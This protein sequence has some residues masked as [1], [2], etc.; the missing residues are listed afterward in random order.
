MEV[1]KMKAA[2]YCDKE[3]IRVEEVPIPDITDREMLLKI[4]LACICGT[5][6]RIFR[7]GH[8]KIPEGAKRVLGHELVG[9][10]VK[11][12]AEVRGFKTGQRV[13][14]A[15]NVGCGVCDMCIRGY[16]HMCPEYEAFG[17]S[18]DGGF[19]EYMKIPYEA[20]I[21]GN[22][23]R[24][25]EGMSYEEAVLAEP[26]SCCFN[27]FQMLQTKPTDYVLIIGAGPIGAMHAILHQR[28]GAA[29]VIMADLSASRLEQMR[30]FGDFTLI[31]TSKEELE[32][33]LKRE[34]EGHGAD[35][36]ITA[37]SVPA[38]QAQALEL[39]APLGR[40]SFFGGLPSG[41]D[42]VGLHTNLIH[43]KEL[44]VVAT[45]GSSLKQYKDAMNI[46]ATD[47]TDIAGLITDMFGIDDI[48][49][50]FRHAMAGKGLKTAIRF[51]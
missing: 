8:F 1:F 26:F 6:Q 51:D 14:V 40:I 33:A 29:K 12:G 39:A 25:P 34:T 47:Q 45:T 18:Y 38:V 44:T 36:V 41:R 43:Y 4:K 17:I 13:A 30:M 20:V 50:A 7:F 19:E 3:E 11:V 35:V 32:A 23:I 24:I 9:E 21:H 27:S 49:E 31:D 28:A 10:L 46:I 22:V 48:Q 16:N 37:C 42:E 2:Y 15:P 5:D